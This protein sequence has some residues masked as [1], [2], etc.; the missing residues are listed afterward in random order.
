MRC[1][2]P[3]GGLIEKRG[4][5]LIP[6]E[7]ISLCI[8]YTC[9][10]WHPPRGRYAFWG[11]VMLIPLKID[12]R[13]LRTSFSQMADQDIK[14][15]ATWAIND[16]AKDVLEYMQVRMDRVFD[17][18]TRFAK[19]ALT[20]RGAKPNKLEAIVEERPSV[21]RR[22]FLKV[23]E[24]G[25]VRPKTGIEKLLAMHVSHGGDFA[26]VIPADG[27]KLDAFGNWSRGERNQVMSQLKAGREV[28]FNSNQTETS[29]KRGKARGR[30]SYFVPKHM[31]GQPR[32]VYK[33]TAKGVVSKIL[34]FTTAMPTYEPRLLF[35]ASAEDEFQMRLP[36]HLQRTF[37]KMAER[38]GLMPP[39]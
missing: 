12:D 35:Y 23:Q 25:G 15:A 33:R 13:Q 22:H 32:G 21:G 3:H 6:A 17:R 16:T 4:L 36:A 34:H 28:G 8:I 24:T 27:A 20:I 26:A 9:A 37:D 2:G 38:R 30:A 18:P 29:K 5:T 1:V 7:V 10:R 31:S 14:V 39:F 11:A 19:N